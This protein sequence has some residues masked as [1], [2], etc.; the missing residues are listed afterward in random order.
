MHAMSSRLALV[1]L[2]AALAAVVA[3][4]TAS[5]SA[6]CRK[7]CGRESECIGASPSG[8]PSFDEGECIAACAALER[9]ED[10]RG[11]VVSHAS[12]VEKASSCPQ[13]L[14]CSK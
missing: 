4:C 7:V 1:G 2:A 10:T 14:E 5:K 13:V 6:V 8:E 12:C 3:A 11:L 9:D